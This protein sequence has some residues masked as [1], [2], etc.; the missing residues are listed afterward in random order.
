MSLKV[1]Y[2]DSV[3]TQK[4]YIMTQNQDGSYSLEDATVYST[5]GDYYGAE[6]LNKQNAAYNSLENDFSNIQG[7][8]SQLNTKLS[9]YGKSVSGN[10]PSA[11][12]AAINELYQSTFN[13]NRTVGQNKVRSNP[14]S[15]GLIS[16]SQ[17]DTLRNKLLT[18]INYL[19]T[20]IAWNGI[21]VPTISISVHDPIT[22]SEARTVR[23]TFNAAIDDTRTPFTT[24]KNA[25][26]TV[27][28]NSKNSLA[29]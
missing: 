22:N 19:Q 27:L 10:S 21:V 17:I 6:D 9:P 15:Y 29:V 25:A 28:N 16:Q 20:A 8:I 12:T 2:Q 14:N 23:N 26:I 1:D 13:A 3:Y 24:F 4:Q 5:E 18:A 11:I 7:L